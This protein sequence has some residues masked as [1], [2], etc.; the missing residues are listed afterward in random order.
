MGAPPPVRTHP[1]RGSHQF[2]TPWSP[3]RH[4]GTVSFEG[5]WESTLNSKQS[6]ARLNI[7][8]FITLEEGKIDR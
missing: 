7:R 8:A 5:G 1:E 2:H 3:L 6:L 4:M